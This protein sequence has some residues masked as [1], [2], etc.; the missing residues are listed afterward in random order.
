M[1]YVK[2]MADV[3]IVITPINP[4]A[5]VQEISLE[6][7]AKREGIDVNQGFVRTADI[8]FAGIMSFLVDA[9]QVSLAKI[10]V[11]FVFL[12]KKQCSPFPQKIR[13]VLQKAIEGPEGIRFNT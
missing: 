2:T 12:L 8:A 9:E 3:Y 6:S 1:V 7:F 11:S 5:D 4:T 10:V 13:R